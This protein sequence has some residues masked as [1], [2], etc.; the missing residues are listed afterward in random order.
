MTRLRGHFSRGD[1][2]RLPHILSATSQMP[3]ELLSMVWTVPRANRGQVDRD[4]PCNG[5]Q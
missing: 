2:K 3:A 4:K 5:W 1:R